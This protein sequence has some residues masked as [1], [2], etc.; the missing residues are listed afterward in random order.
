[1]SVLEHDYDDIRK[2]TKIPSLK[3]A[4]PHADL[5]YLYKVVHNKSLLSN[6]NKFINEYETVRNVR[7]SRNIL[8]YT[9]ILDIKL[10]NKYVINKLWE[11]ANKHSMSIDM[12]QNSIIT[13]T[14]DVKKIIAD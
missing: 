9:D 4:M 5:I 13:Y 8:Y 1:M 6:I 10:S 11:L 2:L 3:T 12:N 7:N 14:K